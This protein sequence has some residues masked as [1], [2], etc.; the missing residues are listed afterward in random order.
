MSDDIDEGTAF[1]FSGN[2]KE[3]LPIAL[4]NLL[5]TI[6]TLGIYRFWA[7]TRERRYF[8]SRTRF[9][10]DRLEWTGTGLEL[11]IGFIVVLALVFVPLFLLQFVVQALILQGQPV[12]AG[13]L[14]LLVYA[15]LFY[16]FG[17]A[18]FRVLRYRLSRTYWHGIRGGSD[19]QGFAY[20][21]SYMWRTVVGFLALGLLIPWSM[22]KLWNQR[23]NAMSFGDHRFEA[24]A[25]WGSIFLRFI[26]C[27]AAPWVLMI[28]LGVAMIPVAMSMGSGSTPGAGIFIV[29]IGLIGAIYIALPLF[30]LAFY[31]A[32]L[33][34]AV[35]AV[36]L[37]EINFAFTARTKHWL[38]LFLGNLGLWLIAAIIAIIPLVAFG[39]FSGFSDLQPGQDPFAGDRMAFFGFIAAIALPI[40]LVGPFIRYRTWRFG[41][42]FLEA[43]GEVDLDLLT[44]ST[45]R[46]PGQGEGLLDAFDV[47]AL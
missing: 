4:T 22:T 5:L 13:V 2:W 7:T 34:E 12:A 29:M 32:F 19:D 23:W 45:T 8:W 47:G 36:K 10:D 14:G 43:T 30:A 16:L 27:Y 38:L 11:L 25:F 40:A 42:R 24:N 1:E 46:E 18:K 6:V 33:R 35:G 20:G 15:A 3:F 39:V 17:I 26:I 44:Q 37:T 41:V 31:A 21:W 28:V 9:I